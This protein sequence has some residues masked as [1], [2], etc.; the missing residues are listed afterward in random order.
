MGRLVGWVGGWGVWWWTGSCRRPG[1]PPDLGGERAGAK[2]GAT[3]SPRPLSPPILNIHGEFPHSPS[4]PVG[5][6]S[7]GVPG[8]R[9]DPV[10]PPRPTHQPIPPT[11]PYPHPTPPRP[12][13]NAFRKRAPN[14]G[15]YFP[16]PSICPIAACTGARW[17]AGPRERSTSARRSSGNSEKCEPA[18]GSIRGPTADSYMMVPMKPELLALLVVGSA[19]PGLRVHL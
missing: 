8:R 3:G 18:W 15:G 2:W 12:L 6:G 19:G 13:H 11:A 5:P 9:Q 17:K 4:W 16:N 1:T 14:V 10:P 7:G